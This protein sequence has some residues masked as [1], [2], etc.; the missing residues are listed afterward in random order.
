MR[1]VVQSVAITRISGRRTNLTTCKHRLRCA[2]NANTSSP[3]FGK[4]MLSDRRGL[5]RGSV[6][7]T[8]FYYLMLAPPLHVLCLKLEA[9]LSE[10]KTPPEQVF[11]PIPYFGT[12]LFSTCHKSCALPPLLQ[13]SD[14]ALTRFSTE[15]ACSSITTGQVVTRYT[16]SL[17]SAFT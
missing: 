9:F 15:G 4:P 6:S 5:I 3:F 17:A 10:S 12:H 14:D 8:C 16:T 7:D 1:D 13:L 2:V 11:S